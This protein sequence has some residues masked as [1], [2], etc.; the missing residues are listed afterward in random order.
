MHID[1]IGGGSQEDIDLYLRYYASET[2]REEWRREFPNHH[3]PPRKVPPFDRDRF[4]P[5]A[6]EE[7]AG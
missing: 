6:H 4:L 3:M 2:D 5:K 7:E 1:V